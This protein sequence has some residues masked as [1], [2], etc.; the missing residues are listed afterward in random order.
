MIEGPIEPVL[1]GREAWLSAVSYWHPSH[2][3]L[4]AW[5]RHA[6]FAS[7]IVSA[8]RPG[9]IVE[10]G[11]HWGY[12]YFVFCE[13]IRRLG[14]SS[15]AFA[16]DSWEGEEHAGVYGSEVY[17]YVASVNDREYSS[18]S[19]LLKGYFDDSLAAFDDGSIDLLHIDGRHRYEDVRH[20]FEHWLPKVSDRGV[21]LFHDI[22][23]RRDDF[24]VWQFW[25]EI[26]G[27]YP[28]FAFEHEHGLGVLGVGTELPEEIRTFFASAAERP[29]HVRRDYEA[30]G[31]DIA[32]TIAFRDERDVYVRALGELRTETARALAE[33]DATLLGLTNQLE[34]MRRSASWR[35]T[36][37]V[38]AVTRS[39]HR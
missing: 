8:L 31:E 35:V 10:L 2:L 17:D 21:V 37:P 30:L 36:A 20:D 25:D 12:S 7:W 1:P 22:T 19:T 14:L 32:R 16:L 23:E 33:R 15:T 5:V 26:R 29:E 39:L 3:P 28:S 34:A 27:S 6:P 38:R 18:F 13:A 11:T 9:T 24:G 4:S